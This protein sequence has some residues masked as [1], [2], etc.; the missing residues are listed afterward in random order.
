LQHRIA[1]AL[2]VHTPPI[3]EDQHAILVR[4]IRVRA[5][6]RFLVGKMQVGHPATIIDSPLTWPGKPTTKA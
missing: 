1:E 5:A 6:D 2:E 3:I 4:T